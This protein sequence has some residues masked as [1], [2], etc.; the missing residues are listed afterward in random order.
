MT[1]GEI[2][3]LAASAGFPDPAL[4]AAIAM[5][6]SGGRANA[7]GPSDSSRHK[8]SN[9]RWSVG[10]WQI[11]ATD[12]GAPGSG[13][14]GVSIAA[15]EDPATNAAMAV[16]IYGSQGYRAWGAY[17]NGSYRRYYTSGSPAAS[18]EP[19]ADGAPGLLDT[20]ID[21]PFG[22]FALPVVVAAFVV[23]YLVLK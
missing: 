22:S 18:G 1:Q 13:R 8:D 12:G 6:E 2:Q 15:L 3:S 19:S 4:A 5:A 14:N 21:T 16:Q 23:A 17:T 11:N 20:K 9:G 7:G 10:L